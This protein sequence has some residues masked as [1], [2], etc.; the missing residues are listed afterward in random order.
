MEEIVLP[1][2]FDRTKRTIHEVRQQLRSRGDGELS[3]QTLTAAFDAA[4]VDGSGRLDREEFEAMLAKC[5]VYL[6]RQDLGTLYREFDTDGSGGVDVNEFLLTLRQNMNSRRKR[7]VN[8]VFVMLDRDGSGALTV[9]DIQGR[10]NTKSIPAVKTGKMTD[11]EA[12]RAF[13]DQFEATSASRDGRVSPEE[14]EDYYTHLSTSFRSDDHFIACLENAWGVPEI[15]PSEADL[16]RIAHEVK[17]KLRTKASDTADDRLAFTSTFK[18]FDKDESG[19]VSADEFLSS[20]RSL[21]VPIAE[22]HLTPLF[23]LYDKD[24]SGTIKY[25]EFVDHL[26]GLSS[27]PDGPSTRLREAPGFAGTGAL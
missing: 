18:F 21:G 11:G 1:E 3:M 16:A 9:E 8:R 12:M 27:I 5:G 6:K 7:M 2:R 20:V 23:N 26:V 10:F 17:E 4:D 19:A 14:F 13:L 24:H 22:K 15:D 25:T